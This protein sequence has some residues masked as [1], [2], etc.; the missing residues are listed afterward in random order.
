MPAR[1]ANKQTNRI[2]CHI[3]TVEKD[4]QVIVE[5]ISSVLEDKNCSHSTLTQK[6]DENRRLE[7]EVSKTCTEKGAR[8]F[9]TVVLLLAKKK[10]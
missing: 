3:E 1:S 6:L 2:I 5:K 8:Y 9:T 7:D 4:S 10:Q